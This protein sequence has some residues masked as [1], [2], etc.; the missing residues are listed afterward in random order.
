MVYI[1]VPSRFP[2]DQDDEDSNDSDAL[3]AL[4][5]NGDPSDAVPLDAVPSRTQPVDSDLTILD[6]G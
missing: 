2:T 3:T 4:N 6:L 5:L 1:F